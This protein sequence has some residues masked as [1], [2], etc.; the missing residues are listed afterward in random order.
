MLAPVRDPEASDTATATAADDRPWYSEEPWLAWLV[1]AFV[2]MTG[3]LALPADL[4][5]IGSPVPVAAFAV[6]VFCLLVSVVLL[7]RQGLFRSAAPRDR[8]GANARRG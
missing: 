3:I 6:S 4:T 8:V 5:R 7:L 2:P 1:A